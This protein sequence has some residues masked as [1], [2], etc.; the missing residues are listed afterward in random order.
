[1]RLPRNGAMRHDWVVDK[2]RRRQMNDFRGGKTVRCLVPDTGCFRGEQEAVRVDGPGF[3]VVIHPASLAS[4]SNIGGLG[5]CFH[6]CGHLG[7]KVGLMIRNI[8]NDPD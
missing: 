8:K 6:P 2:I 4:P 5:V 3:R 1:M 7:N